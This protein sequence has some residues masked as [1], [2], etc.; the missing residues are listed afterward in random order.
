ML[1]SHLDSGSHIVSQDDELRRPAVVIAAKADDV[2]LSH[3]G[4]KIARKLGESKGGSVL[5][6]FAP[7]CAITQSIISIRLFFSPTVD[8]HQHSMA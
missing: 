3:S 6:P 4:R 8:Q 2:P 7:K 5:L 1:P